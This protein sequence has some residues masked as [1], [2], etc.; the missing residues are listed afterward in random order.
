MQLN[1][2]VTFLPILAT[3]PADRV[4]AQAGSFRLGTR[5]R[6]QAVVGFFV[7]EIGSEAGFSPNTVVFPCH[8]NST[9]APL[10]A[11]LDRTLKEDATR[12]TLYFSI[13]TTVGDVTK[14]LT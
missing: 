7:G 11:S 5:V 14:T 2:I 6:F 3:R 12:P 4:N 1:L 8:C 13:P 10:T 9:S